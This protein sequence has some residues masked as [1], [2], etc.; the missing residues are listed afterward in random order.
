MQIAFITLF[1]G[2]ALGSYPVQ[3]AVEGPVATVEL[4]LDGEAVARIAGPPWSGEIDFGADLVPHELVARALDAQG[5]ELARARQLINLPRPP[6]EVEV[7]LE[8]GPEGRPAA[9][10][11]VF[12][13]RTGAITDEARGTL[14]GQPLAVG[15]HGRGALPSYD[16]ASHHVLS[17]TLRFE[18]AVLARTDA[19]FGGRWG[20]SVSASLTALP[21]QLRRGGTPS[22]D[23]LQ[24]RLLADGSVLNVVAVEEGPAEVLIVRDLGADEA[25]AELGKVR[26][27]AGMSFRGGRT[28]VEGGRPSFDSQSARFETALPKGDEVRFLWPVPRTFANPGMTSELFDMSRAY[29]RDD[30]GLHWILTSVARQSDAGK[31]RLADSVAVA[32]LQVLA[33]NRRRSVILVV[34]G[35]PKDASRSDPA[36]VRRYLESIR[37]PLFVWAVEKG[38]AS[39]PA[40]AAWGKVEDVSTVPKLRTAVG[41]LRAELE[42]QRIV[43]VEG[44]HLPG[45]IRLAP[46][47]R[48]TIELP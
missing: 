40:L 42:S 41:R 4:L 18:D 1:L 45:S 12:Q 23:A 29:T 10:R 34:G 37:V 44:T 15:P 32:G 13:S 9:A 33:G 39:S 22:V 30:G 14:D 26:S 6:A 46:S 48:S 31:Q 38:A 21:V 20:E 24:G 11:L 2:L 27:G 36:M 16:P 47:D 17:V 25:L 3:L 7:V 8:R 19:V 43:W 5:K 35:E 28:S